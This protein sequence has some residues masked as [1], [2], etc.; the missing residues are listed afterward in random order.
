[1]KSVDCGGLAYVAPLNFGML[2]FYD[3]NLSD[4]AYILRET[5]LLYKLI[6]YK[7]IYH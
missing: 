1:M 7:L 5:I 4:L 6:L 2:R 3:Y